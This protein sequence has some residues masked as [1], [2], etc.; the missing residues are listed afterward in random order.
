MGNTFHFTLGDFAAPYI[1]A[2]ID[3]ARVSRNN[4]TINFSC[5]A[6]SESTFSSSRRA[7]DNKNFFCLFSC[8]V[9]Q[10]ADANAKI[11]PSHSRSNSWEGLI[12]ELH[13]LVVIHAR[14]DI[15]SSRDVPAGI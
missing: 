15:A 14:G 3:L 10:Y 5:E 4:L 7:D 9:R 6:H 12:L 8:H 1:Q 13:V 11:N 2:F